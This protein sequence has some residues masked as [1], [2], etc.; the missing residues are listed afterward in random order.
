MINTPLMRTQIFPVT[1]QVREDVSLERLAQEISQAGVMF[2]LGSSE[3]DLS[4]F[5]ET[6]AD[7]RM[8][9]AHWAAVFENEAGSQQCLSMSRDACK[10]TSHISHQ[11]PSGHI[12]F[13]PDHCFSKIEN[14]EYSRVDANSDAVL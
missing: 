13:A 6:L 4:R 7:Y 3:E 1:G 9:R 10:V 8:T 14:P 2:S 5:M 11:H 12:T